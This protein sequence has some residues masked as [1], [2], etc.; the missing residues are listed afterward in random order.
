MKVTEQLPDSRRAVMIHGDGT[1]TVEDQP[2]PELGPKEVLVKTAVSLISA[3]TE[4]GGVKRARV[5]PSDHEPRT[6]GYCT[7]GTI[8]AIGS[9]VTQFEVGQRIIGMA[10]ECYNHCN[11]NV[12]HP[13]VTVPIPEGMSFD[14]AVM[15][16]L[17]A[18]SL[19]AVRRIGPEL[20]EFIAVVGQGLVGQFANQLIALSG[21]HAAAVDLDQ[22]RLE[23]AAELGAEITINSAQEDLTEALMA[24]AEGVGIDGS[25]VA[26]G[27]EGT[28]VISK[29]AAA[30]LKAPD[31]HQVGRIVIV[32]GIRAQLGF[33][34]AFGNL[35][36]RPSSR[37]GPGYHDPEYHMGQDYPRA[38]VRWTTRRNMVELL[39]LIATGQFRVKE[40]ITHR[41]GFEQTPEAYETI[42]APT[43]P[44]AA[45]SREDTGG[46]C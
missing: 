41:F 35:D 29:L 15:V 10:G 4:T 43:R 42:I 25:L 36:I 18:T 27:G 22:Q 38:Y 44:V 21:G 40:L 7:A 23:V 45:L 34:T 6:T 9:E 19:Q 11:F 39:R 26:Y 33:P 3:G 2:L 20:G 31:G 5:N 13:Q 24:W 37:T 1:I 32:G 8:I 12:G 30:T 14:E 28:E 46:D 17:A 16:N